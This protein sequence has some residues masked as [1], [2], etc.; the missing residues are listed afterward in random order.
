MSQE[1]RVRSAPS[2]QDESYLLEAKFAQGIAL[3]ATKV[4]QML[5]RDFW[6]LQLSVTN[7]VVEFGD[8]GDVKP[9]LDVTDG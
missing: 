5:N 2:R 4:A 7:I 6:T 8:L 1:L 9:E 3:I